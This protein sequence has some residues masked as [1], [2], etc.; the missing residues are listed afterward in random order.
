M[1]A[2]TE[3]AHDLP[4]A[5]VAAYLGTKAMEPVAEKLYEWESEAD[6]RREDAVRPGPPFEIAAAK[7]L[8]LL[9]REPDE[10]T[11]KRLGLAFHHGLAIGC[12]PTYPMLRR[13]RGSARSR[14]GS[15]PE[16]QCGSPPTRRS[17]PRSAS[18]LRTAP[19]RSRPTSGR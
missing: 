19:T 17:R 3:L 6:R 16:R 15:P 13:G 4:I 11:T 9:G 2:V 1:S 14:P 7:T 12:A 5:T 18:A 8:R 10:Q